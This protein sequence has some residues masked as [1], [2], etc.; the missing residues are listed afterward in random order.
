MPGVSMADGFALVYL[1]YLSLWSDADICKEA[2]W[3]EKSIYGSR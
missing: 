2:S 1:K 3:S